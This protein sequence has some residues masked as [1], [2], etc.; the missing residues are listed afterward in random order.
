[1][2][3]VV[4]N[5]TD[6]EVDPEQPLLSLMVPRSTELTETA[7]I[8]LSAVKGKTDTFRRLGTWDGTYGD[9][10]LLQAILLNSWREITEQR[11]L[12]S[13]RACS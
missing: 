4:R 8:F 12:K 13:S 3:D 1:M 2:L 7:S 5:N 11:T 10:I 6:A 9:Y